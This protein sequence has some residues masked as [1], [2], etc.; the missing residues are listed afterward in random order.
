MAC[1]PVVYNNWCYVLNAKKKNTIWIH[2]VCYSINALLCEKINREEQKNTNK[3]L[4]K[5][6][7]NP[8]SKWLSRPFLFSFIKEFI[9]KIKNKTNEG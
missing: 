9:Q 2:V 4:K 8:I 7:H 6:L 1:K 3:N 5:F